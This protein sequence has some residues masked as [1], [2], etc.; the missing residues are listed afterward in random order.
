MDACYRYPEV[1]ADIATMWNGA[2]KDPEF[3]VMLD[4]LND[5]VRWHCAQQSIDFEDVVS[6]LSKI[7]LPTPLLN[8]TPTMLRPPAGTIEE[9]VYN[10]RRFGNG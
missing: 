3:L 5:L 6:K 1:V 4:A 2:F 9:A 7:T 8:N 10:Y